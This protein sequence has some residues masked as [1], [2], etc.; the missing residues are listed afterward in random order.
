MRSGAVHDALERSHD[1]LER[2]YAFPEMATAR[3][4]D[5]VV[6]RTPPGWRFSP[7]AGDQAVP[8]QTLEGRIERS[9]LDAEHA[10]GETF[11][12][13]HDPVGVHRLHRE[14]AE[15]QHVERALEEI[16]LGSAGLARGHVRNEVIGRT[17]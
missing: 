5:G 3:S 17:P 16:V 11:D 15:D 7:L 13:T 4:G 9:M 12:V 6:S 2:G 10:A 8:Q 14:A 1:P